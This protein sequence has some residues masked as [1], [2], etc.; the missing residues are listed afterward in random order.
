EPSRLLEAAVGPTNEDLNASQLIWEF[1]S[2]HLLPE[3]HRRHAR[4]QDLL[5]PPIDSAVAVSSPV[6]AQ[7]PT[8]PAL[9]TI[10]P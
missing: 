5:A 9:H 1:F 6:Q 10:I 7:P 3:A 2:R 8:E 4:E